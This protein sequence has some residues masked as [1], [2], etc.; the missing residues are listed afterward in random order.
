M[1]PHLWF[2]AVFP[3]LLP[4]PAVRAQFVQPT[5]GDIVFATAP[6]PGGVDVDLALDLYL[7]EDGSGPSPL[8]IYVHG[9]GWQTGSKFPCPA[10][11]MLGLGFAVASVEYRLSGQAKWPAQIQD[12]KA[13]VRWLR[14]NA[15]TYGIDPDRFGVFGPS[16]GGHLASF[17]TTSGGVGQHRVGQL[18]VDLEGSLGDHPGVSSRVQAAVIYFGPSN[19]L[20]MSLFPSGIAHDEVDSGESKLIGAPI[21][22]VPEAA[23]SADPTQHV[24]QDD[25]PMLFVHGTADPVVPYAQSEHIWRIGREVHGLDNWRLL[26]V[27]E[28]GHGGP[29]FP[30]VVVRDWFLEH[31]ADRPNRVRVEVLAPA[32]EGGPP[33]QFRLVRS[34]PLE[35]PL[36]VR[37][38]VSG[39]AVSGVDLEP[40]PRWIDLGPG[41][42]SREIAVVA[43]LD[44]LVEGVETLRLAV[45]P[46]EGYFADQSGPDTM[47]PILDADAATGWPMVQVLAVDRVAREGTSDSARVRFTRSGATALP[48]A[49]H[50][51]VRGD[52]SA[53][54]DHD[55]TSQTILIP[56]GATAADLVIAAIDD[57]LA[58]P[59]EIWVVEL[60]AGSAY[61]RGI[62][63]IASGHIV[64]DDRDAQPS[65]LSL[66]TQLPLAVEGGAAPVYWL[67][68]TGNTDQAAEVA[69]SIHGDAAAG[70]DYSPLSGRAVFLP[71]EAQI[72]VEFALVD[73]AEP[74]GLEW[75]ELVLGTTALHV[76]VE[77]ASRRAWIADD[78]GTVAAQVLQRVSAAQLGR[79][80]AVD[81]RAPA[82]SWCGLYTAAGGAYVPLAG[83]VLLLDPVGAVPL[84][85]TITSPAGAAHFHV[86]VPPSPQLL[87]LVLHLATVAVDP[88]GNV[89]TSALATRRVAQRP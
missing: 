19:F 9:G 84:G 81:V 67:S 60:E 70:A 26:A 15:T 30:F 14:A 65:R 31:L 16:A 89:H 35:S 49:V 74:E 47:L 76:N 75:V 28:G 86:M 62:A 6:G 56:S 4:V 23:L 44:G 57:D 55:A 85:T 53:G 27:P 40:L 32:V 41:E 83:T 21:Q 39:S 80:L 82:G 69:F 48:L 87:G 13:A 2:C 22:T 42:A 12:C 68:R 29:G 25:G 72:P 18:L 79:G 63:R 17:V 7:P 88:L 33:G 46:G 10:T 50:Y 73:D 37:L 54:F 5:H 58:E 51:S 59:A 1:K 8:V 61:N 77:H 64:D 38:A 43:G 66:I 45:G 3:C 71:G 11:P 20:R 52:A 78:D 24:S 34:G 36:S